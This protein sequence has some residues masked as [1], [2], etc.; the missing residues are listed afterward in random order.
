MNCIYEIININDLFYYSYTSENNLFQRKKDIKSST[1]QRERELIN[2]IT[3]LDKYNIK[4]YV[5]MNEN[6]ILS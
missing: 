4:Y 6:I 2:I 3:A 5:D 1:I